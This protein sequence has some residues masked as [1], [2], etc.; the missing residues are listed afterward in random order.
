MK[1]VQATGEA[2]SPEKRTKH[3][4]TIHF[5]TFFLLVWDSFGHLDQDPDPAD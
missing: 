1:D 4:K 3:F 5:L 2:S